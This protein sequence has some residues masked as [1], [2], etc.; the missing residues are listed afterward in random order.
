MR[1]HIPGVTDYRGLPGSKI[2]ALDSPVFVSRNGTPINSDNVLRRHVKPVLKALKLP[3][4]IDLHAMRHTQATLAD[5]AGATPAERQKI[6]GHASRRMTE[7]YTHA[8]LDRVRPAMEGASEGIG[9]ALRKP[10]A[11]VVVIR[12]AR[13]AG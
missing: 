8:E 6:L 11:K 9:E 1:P 10:A 3:M 5:Q 7:S 13:R 2:P 4:E 12:K